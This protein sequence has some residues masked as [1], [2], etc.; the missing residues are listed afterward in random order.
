MKW[1]QMIRGMRR[2]ISLC[3]VFVC[4]I[5]THEQSRSSRTNQVI[6][7]LQKL[8]SFWHIHCT[9]VAHSSA[10]PLP[11][12]SLVFRLF[13]K[14]FHFHLLIRAALCCS[15]LLM[16]DSIYL[17]IKSLFCCEPDHMS[18]MRANASQIFAGYHHQPSHQLKYLTE[19]DYNFTAALF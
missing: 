17:H 9:R 12:S 6:L 13:A 1:K 14:R 4:L 19:S 10:S 15:L 18:R 3:C 11:L 7:E 2:V 16:H 5:G 8:P